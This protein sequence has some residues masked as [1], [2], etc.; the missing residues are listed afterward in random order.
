MAH[1]DIGGAK[2]FY[3][4]D[5]A[6]QLLTQTN[7]R[8][9]N[10]NY[11]YDAAG[12]VTRIYDAAIGQITD[13]SYDHAGNKVRERTAQGGGVYQNNI[14]AYDALGRLRQVSD[15]YLRQIIDYDANNG[16]RTRVQTQYAD[17][18][19]TW[20]NQQW[21]QTAISRRNCETAVLTPLIVPDAVYDRLSRIWPELEACGTLCPLR[22]GGRWQTLRQHSSPRPTA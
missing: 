14:M 17:S 10:L 15:N 16:N 1:T 13:Y 5:N 22:Q 20:R 11:S 9:Q 6:R 12:Q 2:Y 7:T 8:G 18:S 4:Y 19:D 3:T 21:W